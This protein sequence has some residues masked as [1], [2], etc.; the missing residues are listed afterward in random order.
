MFRK[1]LVLMTVVVVSLVALAFTGALLY[2]ITSETGI[3]GAEKRYTNALEVGKGVSSYI[4]QIATKG[5]L[6]SMVDCTKTGE[7]I[8]ESGSFR[9]KNVGNY[10]VEAYLLRKV[11][12]T[13]SPEGIYSFKVVVKN[14]NNEKERS[15]IYFVYEVTSP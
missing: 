12:A 13:T 4:M 11:P 10:E 5:D 1:G 9:F 2:L 6:C 15:E 8:S 14:K 3:S 7:E